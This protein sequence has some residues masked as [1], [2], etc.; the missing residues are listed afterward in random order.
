MLTKRFAHS[1]GRNKERMV[2]IDINHCSHDLAVTRNHH[3]NTPVAC[4]VYQ[5]DLELHALLYSYALRCRQISCTSRFTTPFCPWTFP[6]H[7]IDL[8]C[9]IITCY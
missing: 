1:E 9:T 4:H 3:M 2:Y 7:K 8:H 5:F 6:S